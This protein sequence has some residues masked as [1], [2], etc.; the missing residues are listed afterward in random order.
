MTETKK[1]RIADF[2]FMVIA[3]IATAFAVAAG[4]WLATVW[5]VIAL[6]W[7]IIADLRLVRLQT[8]E[9]RRHAAIP[10]QRDE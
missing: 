8:V 1:L 7:A 2:G 10:A 6:A 3:L 4:D 9:Q 5:T